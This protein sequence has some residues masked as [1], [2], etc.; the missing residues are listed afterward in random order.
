MYEVR[1]KCEK[2]TPSE[3]KRKSDLSSNLLYLAH[4]VLAVFEAE[5]FALRHIRFG[6]DIATFGARDKNEAVFLC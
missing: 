5:D 4:D 6:S 3:A 1:Q 2:K